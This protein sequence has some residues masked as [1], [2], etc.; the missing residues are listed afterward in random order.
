MTDAR[1]FRQ[2]NDFLADDGFNLLGHFKIRVLLDI[3]PDLN[4]VEGSFRARM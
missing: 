4:E 2:I 3:S 1:S